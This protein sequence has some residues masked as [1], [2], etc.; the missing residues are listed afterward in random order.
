MLDNAL[1]VKYKK[2]GKRFEIF[3]DKDK[4]YPYHTGEY[5]NIE[6]VLIDDVIFKD[7]KK[8]ERWDDKTLIDVFGT[9]DPYSIADYI[10]KHGEPPITTEQRREMTEEKKRQILEIIRRE[11]IDPRTDAPHTM[12][13]LEN[14][15][16]QAKINID[17]FKPAAQQVE[18]VIKALRPIIPIKTEHVNIAIRIPAVYASKAYGIIKEYNPKKE[19][20]GSNGELIALVE[21][22]AGIQTELYSKLNAIT[23]GE[24]QTK[25]ISKVNK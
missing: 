13:R 5:D 7:G 3:V 14:A 1:I 15:F 18:S 17:P 9:D 20:W 10:L 25:I 16:E 4:A 8:G 24:V 19:E 12:I 22:P 6:N 23:H 2:D 11:T 21:I